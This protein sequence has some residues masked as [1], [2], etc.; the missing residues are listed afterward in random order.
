MSKFLKELAAYLYQK[1]KTDLTSLTVI[2][3]NRRSGLFFQKYLS[4][5][6]DKPMFS[7][8]II[9]IT[10]IVS[11]ISKL[12]IAEQNK[13]V[14]ELHRVF[15]DVIKSAE[16]IDDFYY[17]GEM[18]LADFNDLDKY[19]VDAKQLFS[20]IES[21]K[22]IDMGFDF[23]TKEQKD[24]LSTFW[25]NILN[26]RNS[27]NKD[28]FMTVW[29]NMFAIYQKF[30]EQLACSGWAYEGML[31]R[32]MA[33]NL[34]FV[35]ANTLAPNYA[36]IGFNA[37]NNCEKKLFK[38]LDVN[39]NT[40]FFWDYDEYYMN[41][42]THEAA[43]FMKE[44]LLHFPMPEDFS[45]DTNN[46]ST[47]NEIDVVSIPGFSGQ[48]T[49]ASKWLS[50]NKTEVSNQ[51]DNTAVVMCD[52]TLLMPLL[53]V[54]P[55]NVNEF[56]ITMGFP[57][58][59]AP[60]YA[61][62]KGLVDIDR[63]SRLDNNGLPIFYYRNVM[64]L[65][66]NPLLKLLLND[67]SETLLQKIKQEN[68]IY[69]SPNDFSDQSFLT[70]VFFLP[71]SSDKCKT[72]LH[73]I[74]KEIFVLLSD[75]DK[76]VKES[77]YQLYLSINRLHES[78]FDAKEGNNPILSKKLYYQ[79]LLRQLDRLMIP[80]EGEPLSGVQLMGFLETRTLDFDNIVL[81]SFNDDKLPG[82]SHQHSF[83][84]YSLRRGFGLPVIE[85]RN[86]MYAYYFYRLIQRAKKVT[87]VYDSRTEGLSNG[88]VSR[89]ATQLKYEASH[90]ELKNKQAVFDFEPTRQ[91]AIEVVKS[92]ALLNKL[93]T[94]IQAKRISPSAL[95]TYIDCKLKYFFKYIE[96]IYEEDEV[97]EDI[98]HLV[99]GRIAHL[100]LEELYQPFV[101][102]EIK[103]ADLERIL[104]DKKD[105]NLSLRKALEKEYFKNGNFNLNGR[106]LLVF[107]IIKKYVTRIIKYDLS[108]APFELLSL[109]QMYENTIEIDVLGKQLKVRF[110]GM[111]D[112]L[113]RVGNVIRV[114]DYKTG[115][116][117]NKISDIAQL[118]I[119]GSAR[120]KAAFQ[121]MIYANCVYETIKS[122]LP[123]M[124]AVY[125]A[126]K[127]F[128]ADFDPLFELKG[129][130]RLIYQANAE[131][132]NMGL[133]MLLEELMNSDVPF[134]Q[135]DKA[136]T[137]QY[138]E[139]NGI[140]NR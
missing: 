49:Y 35:N 5:L 17:W 50:E 9:T 48:A 100:A 18:M 129:K 92:E 55:S 47:L 106:N 13:L 116:S 118:F 126:R 31:Y 74:I 38:Y 15:C 26:S 57:I 114:V 11:D 81:L 51:F 108:I 123:V 83:I 64:G 40:N 134:T 78:I 109:E 43:L 136:Q 76:I 45:F 130:G 125:G 138:C 22:E 36:I 97:L 59:S 127:V 8:N 75:E 98:D 85:Q 7:P 30:S 117:E 58:K 56:N 61:L 105:L 107:D 52:E 104:S 95:N 39:S 68:K 91:K 1:H 71:Q 2:F 41:S 111:V 112:R 27:D 63:S 93:E 115:V 25:A 77:L 66:S 133:K 54:L 32:K 132:F 113:D 121:T 62:I 3:P 12:K 139:F 99:F 16:P 84:P 20:N 70:K 86:A 21:L 82:K 135:T 128:T 23:L 37:L 19:L 103:K 28:Q 44:N 89:Y 124:P 88:E 6:V 29:K 65:L 122:T 96:G 60:A 4:E 72:Y 140:C 53:N 79:L 120:N 87:L 102:K 33:D 42:N 80:F 101:N 24:Y 14:I 34:E 94:F 131:D 110:G 69:L 119:S 67:Y 10:E 73:E 137:C 46:F 90:L